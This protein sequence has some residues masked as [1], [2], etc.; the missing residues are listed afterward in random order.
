MESLPSELISFIQPLR[1]LMRVEVF[2]S[3]CFL[4]MGILIGEAKQG[5][6]RASVFAPAV[7]QPQRLSDLFCRHKLSHQAFMAALARLVL[8]AL[9]PVGLPVRLFWLADSTQTEKPYAKRVASVGWFHRTKRVAGRTQKLKGQCYV[10][11]AHLYRYGQGQVWASVLVGAL[12]YVK[13]RSLSHLTGD[14]LHQLRLPAEVGHVWIVDRGLLTRPVLRAVTARGQFTLG[15]VKCNQV[16]Y[17]AP[18][19]QARGR[20][21]K[22][23]YGVKCRVD[24]LLR[25]FAH[26]LQHRQMKLRVRGRERTV[27]LAEAQVLLRGVWA[28]RPLVVRVLIVTVPCSRLKRWYLLTTD[29]ELEVTEAVQAYAGRQQVEVNFDEIKE[30]GL[31]HYMGRSGQGVRRWP[32]FLCAA[33]LLLKLMAT[34]VIEVTLPKLHWS[35]Y[36]NE[37]SVGQLRRRLIEYCRPRIS[38]A[39]GMISNLQEIRKA[40]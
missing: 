4:L 20:G 38:R 19:D 33:H 37:H 3:F 18:Q 10:F 11:A 21:R 5:T 24:K 32:L 7:Y 13:G 15:R 23:A 12:L 16:V 30:L 34:E 35:W 36:R 14:L 2:E 9:Y 25:R 1:L 22:K 6:V 27:R 26:R 17:F 29:L 8:R 39:V 28:G 40:A 31:G